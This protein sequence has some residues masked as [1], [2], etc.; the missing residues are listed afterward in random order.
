[1]EGASIQRIV[2]AVT[3]AVMLSACG[4]LALG[5]DNQA[6]RMTGRIRELVRES[7]GLPPATPRRT[8]LRAEVLILT[9]RHSLLT[10]A[11]LCNYGALLAF[12]LASLLSLAQG[13]VPLGGE[14]VPFAVFT[15][16]V[17]LLAGMA[18]LTLASVRLSRN[19]IR[20]EEEEIAAGE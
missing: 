20:H 18:V 7:R 17:M 13:I 19:A 9:R 4:L 16:G 12:V 8:A 3:P 6:A 2:V 11:L 14:A 15:V 5:L 10:T 1:M